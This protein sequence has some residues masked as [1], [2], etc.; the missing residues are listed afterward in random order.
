MGALCIP[1]GMPFARD[2]AHDLLSRVREREPTHH[3]VIRPTVRRDDIEK[4]HVHK[5]RPIVHRVR[6]VRHIQPVVQPVLDDEDVHELPTVTQHRLI[7]L[8]RRERSLEW[9]AGIESSMRRVEEEV[10]ELTSGRVSETH[11]SSDGQYDDEVHEVVVNEVVEDVRP[12]RRRTVRQPTVV[13][14]VSPVYETV[15]E[16]GSVGDIE[17]REV[18]PAS[19]WRK[20]PGQ[21]AELPE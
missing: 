9:D 6:R 5:T 7:P 18:V 10:A 16:T 3:K 21:I 2:V 11:V 8:Q 20:E 19:E 12:V 13:E 1:Y 14:E 4:V 17:W 15:T